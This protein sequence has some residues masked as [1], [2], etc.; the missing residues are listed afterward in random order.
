MTLKEF[1]RVI[2]RLDHKHDERSVVI[3]TV[4][5]DYDLDD[6]ESVATPESVFLFASAVEPIP[7]Q[8]EADTLQQEADTL[9]QRMA[10]IA[11]LFEDTRHALA[12]E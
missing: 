8:Q 1:R 6:V 2:D 7:R 5:G 9:Q 12:I 3:S 11:R 10:R 4:S